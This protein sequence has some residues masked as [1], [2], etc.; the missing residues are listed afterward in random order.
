MAVNYPAI[1][2]IEEIELFNS[3][4]SDNQQKQQLS[5]RSP[6]VHMLR[7]RKPG[8]RSTHQTFLCSFSLL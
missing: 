4:I 3:A 7:Q 6:L 2:L 5:S 8:S 1:F